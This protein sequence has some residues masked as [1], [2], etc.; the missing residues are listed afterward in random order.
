MELFLI[1]FWWLLV[2]H[3]L[4][5]YPLQG[6]AMATEKDRHSK[7]PLQAQVPWFYW[8][9]AHALIHGGAVA[10]ITQSIWLGLA[11]TVLHWFIDFIKCD[12]WT[13]IHQ[14]QALHVACKVVWAA[15]TPYVPTQAFWPS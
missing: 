14:D 4:V 9:T 15:L 1:R 6:E 2:G 5:D 8:L 7:S 11:E 3:A 12:G 10:L 13:N